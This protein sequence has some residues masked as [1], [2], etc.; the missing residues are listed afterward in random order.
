MVDWVLAPFDPDWATQ[1]IQG[2]LVS[3][4]GLIHHVRDAAYEMRETKEKGVTKTRAGHG[5]RGGR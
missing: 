5:R 2:G 1:R 4:E 3:G